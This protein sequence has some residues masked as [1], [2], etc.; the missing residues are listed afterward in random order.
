MFVRG[1]GSGHTAAEM[2]ATINITVS[3]GQLR[4]TF[5]TVTITMRL[6]HTVTDA[7]T[8]ASTVTAMVTVGTR[9]E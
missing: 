6:Y 1:L 9:S 3:F 2:M 7:V 8:M 5:S 4:S